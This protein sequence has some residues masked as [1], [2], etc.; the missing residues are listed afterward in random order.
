M[1]KHLWLF[2]LILGVPL[3]GVAVSEGI[4]AYTNS[5][6]RASLREQFTDVDPREFAS[7]TVDFICK[8]HPDEIREVVE[9]ALTG[10]SGSSDKGLYGAILPKGSAVTSCAALASGR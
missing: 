9:A 6:L 5:E 3:A 8:E 4:Q 2:G 1:V 7:A 10:V